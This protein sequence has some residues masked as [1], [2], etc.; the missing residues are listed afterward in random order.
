MDTNDDET[1]VEEIE[2]ENTLT[3]GDVREE[4]MQEEDESEIASTQE[5]QRFMQEP[6]ECISATG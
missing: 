6:N 1:K 4:E 2:E 5:D 3:G